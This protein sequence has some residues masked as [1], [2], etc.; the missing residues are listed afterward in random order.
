MMLL[1]ETLNLRVSDIDSENMLIRINDGKGSK[2][3][4]TVLSLE[5]LK[6]LRRYWKLYRPTTLLF[7][8]MLVDKPL[9]ARNIQFVF[10]NADKKLVFRNPVQS[11]RFAIM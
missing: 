2:D 5:N 4:L 9:A 6:L 7:P 8:G 11:I 10:Q 1:S 3:R